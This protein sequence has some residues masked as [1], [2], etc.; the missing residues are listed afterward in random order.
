MINNLKKIMVSRDELERRVKERTAELAASSRQLNSEIEERK[1][2][3]EN[4]KATETE[5]SDGC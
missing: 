1:Q 2:T 4:L 5:I 3:E